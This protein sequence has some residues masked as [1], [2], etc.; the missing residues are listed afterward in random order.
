MAKN[1]T[2]VHE[3]F[4]RVKQSQKQWKNRKKEK[5]SAI[6]LVKNNPIYL[7]NSP[8]NFLNT[9]QEIMR[10]NPFQGEINKQHAIITKDLLNLK[11]E[12]DKFVN[13]MWLKSSI[14][15]L[16][17]L[18]EIFKDISKWIT[19]PTKFSDVTNP[20]TDKEK[21]RTFCE[22]WK[23]SSKKFLH[24]V[25]EG[26][27]EF[28]NDPNSR[29]A[30]ELNRL[31][32][33]Y[34][35]YWE[36]IREEKYKEAYDLISKSS[37]QH[38]QIEG[39]LF[40][41]LKARQ[42]SEKMEELVANKAIEKLEKPSIKVV[43]KEEEI[44]DIQV[45]WE[46]LS[47]SLNLKLN[48]T[49]YSLT[50]AIRPSD[51]LRDTKDKVINQFYY[52]F[53][54]MSNLAYAN[55]DAGLWKILNLLGQIFVYNGLHRILITNNWQDPIPNKDLPLFVVFR[56]EFV[57]TRKLLETYTKMVRWDS[58]NYIDIERI[59]TN[60]KND[61]GKSLLLQILERKEHRLW[62]IEGENE[63]NTYKLLYDAVQDLLP[64][65]NKAPSIKYTF[66]INKN[67]VGSK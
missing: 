19:T 14:G 60:I 2:P 44:A 61:S 27:K 9:Y 41:L 55:N 50:R 11:K 8:Y 31:F 43:G 10:D 13:K 32:K 38:R 64:D 23:K 35:K 17:F 37:D 45:E 6:G 26:Y 39:W 34:R 54:N 42:V 49:S 25:I 7:H 58:F 66:Y 57:L 15:L 63:E 28:C 40:E 20:K 59:R 33:I 3:K 1:S 5:Y 62:F 24:L 46:D 65:I 67:K 47:F 30:T 21:H 12:E 53:Y 51:I 16:N 52:L 4:I 48:D 22:E 29:Y 56:D 36:L 18:N